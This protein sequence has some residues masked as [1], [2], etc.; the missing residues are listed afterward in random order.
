MPRN[1]KL[2]NIMKYINIH[3][4]NDQI[5]FHAFIWVNRTFTLIKHMAFKMQ[6]K[7]NNRE[8]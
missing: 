7:G 5:S 3:L 2:S 1:D 4:H 6:S 8:K